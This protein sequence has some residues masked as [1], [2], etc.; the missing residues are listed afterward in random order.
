MSRIPFTSDITGQF[1]LLGTGTSVGVP[2]LGCGCDVCRSD[3]PRNK[4]TRC[5]VAIGLPE[6]VLLIDTPPDL[7]VQLLREQI[8]LVHAAAFTHEHADH[9]FGLDDL[10]LFQFYLGHSVPIY[11]EPEVESRIRMAFD[12]AF[13]DTP[14]THPGATPKFDIHTIGTEPFS[15]LGAE[16]RPFRLLHGPRFNVLGFR[17]NDI[18]YCTDTN[19][20]PD[21]TWPALQGLDVLILDALRYKSHPTHFSLSEAVEM[22]ERIGARQTYFTHLSHEFD[23]QVTNRELP[24]NMSLAYDGL[25][26]PLG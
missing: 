19:E 12:Y 17:V 3:D 14:T 7:R 11:C 15:V 20:I 21:A 5:A 1:V 16:V 24:S 26:I 4:R 8:G 2:A 18:A 25:Q 6:G 13:S 10:R 9:V 22:A 23:F